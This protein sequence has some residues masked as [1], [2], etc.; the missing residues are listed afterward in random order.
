MKKPV[1]V[2]S[3]SAFIDDK[4]KE[5]GDGRGKTLAKVR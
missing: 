4:I 5:R 3:S 2:E 1:P